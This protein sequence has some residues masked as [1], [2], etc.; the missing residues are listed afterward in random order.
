MAA[1][2]IES[3]APDTP[4]KSGYQS[5]VG[6]RDDPEGDASTDGAD[7]LPTHFGR[8]TC[9]PII[10]NTS[11]EG[12]HRFPIGSPDIEL[13]PSPLVTVQPWVHVSLLGDFGQ[14]YYVGLGE[15][16]PPSP[17]V[18][19]VEVERCLGEET[20]PSPVSDGPCGPPK[21]E[22]HM[23]DGQERAS[24]SSNLGADRGAKVFAIVIH[25]PMIDFACSTYVVTQ[26]GRHSRSIAG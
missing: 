13:K 19:G 26:C 25:P 4:N 5:V 16:P 15:K 22:C 18:I 23:A 24:L 17:G 9:A 2:P 1:E 3:A 8:C 10:S 14:G 20:Q 11:G 12:Q 6:E 7:H 21:C